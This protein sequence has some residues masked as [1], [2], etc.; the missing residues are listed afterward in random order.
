VTLLE[1]NLTSKFDE[2]DNYQKKVNTIIPGFWK[3]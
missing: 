2:Y 3:I 1:A